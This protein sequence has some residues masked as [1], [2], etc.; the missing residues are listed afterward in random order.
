L[1][2][3]QPCPFLLPDRPRFVSPQEHVAR[4]GSA[5]G[6]SLLAN[7]DAS[8]PKFWQ[9]VPP[10]EKNTPQVNPAVP[11]AAAPVDAAAKVAVSA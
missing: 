5:K 8:L 2:L 9:L 1:W 4:T 11:E 6:K 3:S 7:W 10:A